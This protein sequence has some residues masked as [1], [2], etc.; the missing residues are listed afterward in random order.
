[1]HTNPRYEVIITIFCVNY[2]YVGGRKIPLFLLK[3]V[4]VI[5][6]MCDSLIKS[7]EAHDKKPSIKRS[8]ILILMELQPYLLTSYGA[9]KLPKK[10]ANSS[11][12]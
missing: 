8:D 6:T 9:E 11:L 2:Y 12:D 3:D 7:A 5:K 10:F 4:S 1:M